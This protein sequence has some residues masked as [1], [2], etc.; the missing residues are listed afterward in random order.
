MCHKR[1]TKSPKTILI[2][3][4]DF[5]WARFNSSRN[6]IHKLPQ[7][8]RKGK[9]YIRVYQKI[10]IFSHYTFNESINH[11]IYKQLRAQSGLKLDYTWG[12]KCLII[13]KRK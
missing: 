11:I 8:E 5:A 7:I 13:K 1:G 10:S 9:M 4:Y 3:R 6:R 12:N 2:L